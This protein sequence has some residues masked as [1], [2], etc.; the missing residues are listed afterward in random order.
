MSWALLFVLVLALGLLL[1]AAL[2]RRMELSTMARAVEKRERAQRSGTSGA[3]LMQPQIDLSRCLGCGTCV[4]VC[5]EGEVLELVHGQ[6]AVVNGARCVGHAHCE[7]ECPVGAITVTVANLEERRDVPVLTHEL[8]ARGSP[9]LFLAG[10]VTA[11]ALIKSAIEQGAS[12]AIEVARR[13]RE[14]RGAEADVLDLC[15]VGAGPAGLACSLES[16]RQG[17]AFVTLEQQSSIG[18]T[19]AKYPRKKL[20][21]TQPVELPLHGRLEKTSYEKEE[22]V[23]LWQTI[24]RRAELPIR[25]GELFVGCERDARGHW[26]VHTSVGSVRARHVC[27]ALGRRGVPNKLGVPGEDL[28]KVAYDLLDAHSY[29]GQ[30]IL[31]VG[32]GDNA[33]ETALALAEQAGNEVT[34]SYRQDDFFRIRSRNAER[35]RAA[36][37][38]G[39]LQ[40]LTKS[41]LLAVNPHEFELAVESGAGRGTRRLPNDEVF[42]MA[43]GTPP[44]ELLERAGVSFDP[45]L[46]ERPEPLVEQGTGIVP[47]LTAG[48]ALAVITLVW[49]LCNADYYWLA[50]TQRATH[51]R[52]HLLRPGQGIGLWL[53]IVASA[54]VVLNL[55]YLARRSGRLRVGSLRVWMT[56]HV[57]TGILAFLCATLHAAMAPRDSIGG[58]AWW[59]LAALIFTG[60]IGRYVYAWV[61]HAANGR[62][63]ELAEVKAR[64]SNMSDALDRGTESFLANAQREV[65]ERVERVQWKSTFLGRVVAL[66][67]GE[68]ELSRFAAELRRRGREQGSS[69][70]NIEETIVLARRAHRAA[71][72]AAHYEDL[73]GLLASWRWLHRWVAALMVLLVCLHIAHALI[74]GGAFSGGQP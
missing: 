48:F 21:L 38:Q 66:A 22:L 16:K 57:A 39:R 14:S 11:H 1:S 65:I 27:L 5:P 46:R 8:E 28:P 72:A 69:R 6:A 63:Y 18:G 2:V 29:S 17:L 13:S 37:S 19:V 50:P 24:A 67:R 49:A 61:P 25:C 60:A 62:E 58:H 71:L 53:G 32:G 26:I 20:V 30:R 51:E 45:A 74:Y 52:H 70:E 44:I 34:L 73:R 54:L 41:E 4:S 35:L 3:Q 47:A 9:G 36:R 33:V 31:V 42:V 7:R 12:V 64:L 56:S 23:T 15:I 68:R 55:L 40:I 10:E 43:G 59:A